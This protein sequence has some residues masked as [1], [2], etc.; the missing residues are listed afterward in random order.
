M[1]EIWKSVPGYEG[2]YEVSNLGTIKSL[3][4]IVPDKT[5]GTRTLVGRVLRYTT[6]SRGRCSV[7]LS[8]DN[9]PIKK[10]IHLIVAEAFLGPRIK[11][12]EVCHTDGN[13]ANNQAS[14][15]RYG[16][17]K[18]NMEDMV[19]HN[20]SNRGERSPQAVINEAQAAKI[21]A[22]RLTKMTYKEIAAALS[23][24][25][26]QVRCVCVGRTWHWVQPQ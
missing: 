10:V 12:I 22:L 6:D 17:H 7:A 4:R 1:Q 20:R 13:P 11:G 14:N 18:S 26:D 21:K 8:R 19:A 23:L 24:T 15:L 25:F 5:Y 9:K 16:T 3:D 2:L